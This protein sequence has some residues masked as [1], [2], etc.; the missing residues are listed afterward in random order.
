MNIVVPI[1]QIPSLVDE[2]ELNSDGNGLD[3][4]ALTF[5]TNE[6]DEHAIEQAVLIKEAGGATVTVVGV[7]TTEEME[8]ALHTALAKGA[9]KVAIIPHDYAPELPTHAHAKMLA[10][11]IKGMSADLILTGVQ[12]ADDRDGNLGPM[13]AAHLGLPYVGVVAGIK[14]SEGKATIRKEYSGGVM[15][16]FDAKLPVVVGVQ[17]AEQ[18][19]RYAPIS[20]IRQMAKEADVEELDGDVGDVS[21]GSA[22]T[23][24][25]PPE[26]SGHAE[27]MGDDA[28]EVVEKIYE[29]LSE[30]GLI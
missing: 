28:D 4:D 6:F 15:A 23:K 11:A 30:R 27:M 22:V 3:E 9:D 18:P 2:L 26:S 1:K 16:E 13:V 19:P 12:A 10:D 29:L 8:D 20:K 14:V 21:A 25:Y 5:V 24:M 17:A 7:D